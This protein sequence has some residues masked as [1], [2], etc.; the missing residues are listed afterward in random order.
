MRLS[1]FVLTALN[2]QAEHEL[3]NEKK[4]RVLASWA[5]FIGLSGCASFLRKQADGEHE[6]FLKVVS[7]IEDRNEKYISA[8]SVVPDYT[9]ASFRDAFVFAYEIE[10]GTTEKINQLYQIAQTAGDYATCQWLL[11]SAGL[12]KEQVEEE[13][14]TQ[15]ILD[16][17]DTI[18]GSLSFVAVSDIMPAIPDGLAIAALDDFIGGL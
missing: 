17:I 2:A 1:S 10:T 11:D 12:I 18:Y 6:H 4:Y 3:S 5:D 8:G 13:N 16:R 14:L 9:P 7:Y 15:T